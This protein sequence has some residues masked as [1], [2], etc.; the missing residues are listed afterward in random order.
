M[1]LPL[2]KPDSMNRFLDNR[3][4]AAVIREKPV[5]RVEPGAALDFLNECGAG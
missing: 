2:N 1:I 4:K 5:K 3:V